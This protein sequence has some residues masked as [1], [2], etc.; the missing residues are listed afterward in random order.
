MKRYIST[1]WVSTVPCIFA[2]II[3]SYYSQTRKR[4]P[5]Y[6]DTVT[7]RVGNSVVQIS[8]VPLVELAHTLRVTLTALAL[9]PFYIAHAARL[10]PGRERLSDSLRKAVIS[11]KTK[12]LMRK[13]RKK[14]ILSLTEESIISMASVF[15]QLHPCRISI[16]YCPDSR[17]LAMMIVLRLLE[18]F[19]LFTERRKE[20]QG[21]ES[22][23]T[24]NQS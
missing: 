7:I 10:N 2:R 1:L 22:F 14:S 15:G 16:P 17:L 21:S 4:S 19:S 6:Y 18:F 5:R 3:I 8:N 12:T 13:L 24:T 20:L 11:W 23:I 9:L